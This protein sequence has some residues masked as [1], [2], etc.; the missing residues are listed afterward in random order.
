[1]AIKRRRAEC[2]PSGEDDDALGY[3][4]AARRCQDAP[5]DPP[6]V[7]DYGGQPAVDDAAAAGLP[8]WAAE[9][10]PSPVMSSGSSEAAASTPS[11]PPSSAD[12]GISL[13]MQCG[14]EGDAS[15]TLLQGPEVLRSSGTTKMDGDEDQDEA[16]FHFG[17]ELSGSEIGPVQG[18]LSEVPWIAITRPQ[19]ANLWQMA[20]ARPTLR[21]G[22]GGGGAANGATGAATAEI[23]PGGSD[24]SAL[25]EPDTQSPPS[26]PPPP[27]PAIPPPVNGGAAAR[28]G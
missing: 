1:M 14:L 7:M 2:E 3:P 28:G 19:E 18:T 10:T 8:G 9:A 25:H 5:L 26:P 16:S 21:Q 11:S 12:E 6:W 24:F 13:A 23:D 22:G 15:C 20:Q 27:P 17:S 4:L